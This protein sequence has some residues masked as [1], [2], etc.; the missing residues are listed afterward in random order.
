MYNVELVTT[1]Q[2]N[3]I[4]LCYSLTAWLGDRNASQYFILLGVAVHRPSFQI[5]SGVRQPDRA[6]VEFTKFMEF[7]DGRVAF[8]AE[9]AL[10]MGSPSACHGYRPIRFCC[11][12]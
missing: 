2:T 1:G 12:S 8:L 9:M 11:L 4:A 6:P 5:G 7:R 3:H 10:T